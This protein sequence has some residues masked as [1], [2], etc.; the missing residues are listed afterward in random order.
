MEQGTDRWMEGIL[1]ALVAVAFLAGASTA[2]AAVE[3]LTY[4]D[5]ITG[6]SESGPGGSGACTSVDAAGS[7]GANSGLDR[8]R[9][10]ALSP[11]GQWLYTTSVFDDAVARFERD[12]ATGQLTYR[13]CITGETESGPAG[14]NACAQIASASAGG[15]NSG[16]DELRSVVLSPDGESLYASST[17]DD[18]VAWFDRDPAT[19]QLTYAGC[20]TGEMQSGPDGSNACATVQ[21]ATPTGSNSG[22]DALVPLVMSPDGAS[23]YAGSHLDDSLARFQ[24]DPTTGELT[25]RD[26]FTG[27]AQSGAGGSNAC[28]AIP[29]AT[30]GGANS[31]LDSFTSLAMS[32][33]GESVY[34]ASELDDAVA[35]FDRNPLDG[36]LTYAGCI[37]GETG[38]AGACAE[39]GAASAQGVGSGLDEPPSLTVTRDGGSVYT[40]SQFDD[41]VARFDRDSSTGALSYRGCVTG[42]AQFG[43][44]GS[45][46]CAA[47][48]SAA[49]GGVNSGLDTLRAVTPSAD[50]T[51]LY[52][53][54]AKDDG[55]AHFGR[56]ASGALDYRS[57]TS[58]ETESGAA[59]SQ[60]PSAT[61]GGFDS[62][63]S[64]PRSIVASADGTSLYA[65]ARDDDGVARFA[66][67]AAPGG[68]SPPTASFTQ[69][70]AG[71]DCT[72][73]ASGSSDPDGTISSYEWDF[74][75]GAHGT[76]V[77]PVHTYAAGGTYSVILTVTD[78]TGAADTDTE[79]VSVSAGSTEPLAVSGIQPSTIGAGSTP[80]T[81]TG[82][83]FVADSRIFLEGG[84]G[85]TPTPSVTGVSTDGRTINATIA[86]SRK[87]PKTTSQ[88]DV[89]VT[90]PDSSTSVLPG[91]LTVA[92]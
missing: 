78:D 76:G 58:G 75:D 11:D 43:P 59:C 3:D 16:L 56:N 90:N 65:G 32:P 48:P 54:A 60:I 37:T 17:E 1:G 9:S 53:A 18:A 77:A 31:G 38:S 70:C 35:S 62:G 68:N 41:A 79:S 71:L 40:A 57:C 24:R 14:S 28:A 84:K 64:S 34:G 82:R 88:W 5:C 39:I 92:R 29:S 2:N 30:T 69:S 86:V 91:A 47:I 8:L 19:G 49:P 55:I 42:D 27:K 12:P 89:R 72:F 87:G 51:S 50:G 21:S 63:L 22:L 36:Q 25:Y 15:I 10:D 4:R 23:L 85:P 13:G 83:G 20:L 46:A 6:E 52:A 7:S 80:V 74:G 44:S 73:D 33:D 81:I 26:C 45:G 66:R 61:P 67:E